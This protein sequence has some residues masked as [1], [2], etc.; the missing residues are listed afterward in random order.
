MVTIFI[1]RIRRDI[2]PVAYCSAIAS[3]TDVVFDFIHKQ[4]GNINTSPKQR[5]TLLNSLACTK[6]I[7]LINK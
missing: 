6:D 4:Y 2:K 5:G 1:S 3:G 7:A